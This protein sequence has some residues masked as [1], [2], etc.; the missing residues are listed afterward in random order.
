MTGF[1]SVTGS[2]VSEAVMHAEKMV[3]RFFQTHL[4][5]IHDSRRQVLGSLVWMAMLG[6]PLSLSR[7]ARSLARRGGTMK[8]GLKRVGNVR[9]HPLLH[10]AM[11]PSGTR[12]S[13]GQCGDHEKPKRRNL[14]AKCRAECRGFLNSGCP[15]LRCVPVT[16]V[17][18]VP[19][20]A[21]ANG[22]R[23]RSQGFVD[24]Q[25]TFFAPGARCLDSCSSR[26]NA[27]ASSN[28]P[29]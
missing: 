18:V 21:S 8:S 24:N 3:Q 20:A 23:Y 2:N 26:S 22:I 29:R 1:F 12:D 16:A 28:A 17:R 6:S 15:G 25:F 10:W 4:G 27:A 7:L 5:A 19:R 9:G 13:I 14:S 11:A